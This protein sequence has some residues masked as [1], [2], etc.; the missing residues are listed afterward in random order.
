MCVCVHSHTQS[1][2]CRVEQVEVELKRG[3]IDVKKIKV[4]LDSKNLSQ[5]D[6]YQQLVAPAQTF[7]LDDWARIVEDE[8]VQ[9]CKD[10]QFMCMRT[11]IGVPLHTHI[12]V[13]MHT[14]PCSCSA[15]NSAK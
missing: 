4:D 6:M 2:K 10:G 9:V 15:I 13:C 11:H 5:K 3:K 7:N 1:L 12:T 14:H 8:G